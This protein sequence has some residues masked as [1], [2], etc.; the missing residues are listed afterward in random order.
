MIHCI[1]AQRRTR[2]FSVIELLVVVAIVVIAV[3]MAIM[4]LSTATHAA[5]IQE[6][7]ASVA[8][9]VRR[10]VSSAAKS[11]ESRGLDLRAIPLASTVRMRADVPAPLPEAPVLPG[12]VDLQGGTGYPFAEGSNCAVAIVLEDVDDP[13]KI[14]AVVLGRSATVTEYRLSG[15]AWEVMN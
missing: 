7:R 1:H 11:G 13:S 4:V 5:G 12:F 9:A 2:G 6:S 14:V 10:A 15:T 8:S 3:A